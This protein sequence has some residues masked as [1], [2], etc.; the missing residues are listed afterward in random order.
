MEFW[1]KF[2]KSKQPSSESYDVLKEAVID[3]LLIAKLGIVSCVA[4]FFKPFLTAYQADKPIVPFLCNDLFKLIKHVMSVIVKPDV[5]NQCKTAPKLLEID[6]SKM[7]NLLSAKNMN[8][9]FVASTHVEKLIK[10][11]V[12]SKAMI[13][14]FKKSVKVFV[15]ATVRKLV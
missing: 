5:I 2:V 6:L 9:G 14:D 15:T 8:I 10:K 4:S 12:A 1:G 7:E 3:K 11:D 13:T